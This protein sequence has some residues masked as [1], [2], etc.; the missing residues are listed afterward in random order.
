[1]AMVSVG[2]GI[3]AGLDEIWVRFSLSEEEERGVEVS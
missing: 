1:M 2:Q 3:M